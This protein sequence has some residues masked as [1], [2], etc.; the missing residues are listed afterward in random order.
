MVTGTP[1][2]ALCQLRLPAAQAA[3][4]RL[5]A[6]RAATTA[7]SPA[8][9]RIVTRHYRAE[10]DL[11]TGEI[12]ALFSASG[13]PVL[14]AGS[15]RFQLESVPEKLARVAADFMTPRRQRLVLPPC[16]IRAEVSARRAALATVIESRIHCAEF[17]LTRRIWFY[18]DFP[19]IDFDIELD[20]RRSDVLATVDFALAGQVR[21]RTRGIPFGF[22]EGPAEDNWLEPPPYFLARAAEHNLFGYSAAVMPALGWSDYQLAGG[23][24]LTLID[25]GLPMHEFSAGR[26]TLG[27]INAVSTYRGL[28]NEELRGIGRHSFRFALLP[29]EGDWRAAEAPR[30]AREFQSEPIWI[31]SGA[32]LPQLI[33]TSAN[34]MLEAVRREGRDLEVRLTEWRGEPAMAWVECLAPHRGARRTNLLGEDPR[35][36]GRSRRYRFAVLPQE[37]VTLRFE[38]EDAV[39]ALPVLRS[40]ETLV[41]EA[42]RKGLRMRLRQTGHPPRPF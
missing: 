12:S 26:L 40:W 9:K 13:K 1:G 21:R 27:L 33:R 15:G 34:L 35:P 16:G 41:P 28:P 10:I 36:L 31:D 29:H 37:I 18:Q 20:L 2:E 32:P 4:V 17:S 3:P 22:A 24:G 42:R 38:L 14:S 8:P 25:D 11:E 6:G 7:A 39:E 5:V 30:R 19:R 23:G